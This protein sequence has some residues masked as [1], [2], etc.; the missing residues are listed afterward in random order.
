MIFLRPSAFI[1]ALLAVPVVLL[2]LRRIP[3]VRRSVATGFLWDQVF[4]DR[5]PGVAQLRRRRR[6][7]L[8]IQL[9]ILAFLVVALA[10]PLLHRPQRIV[11]VV[12]NSS[13]GASL[14][15]TKQAARATVDELGRHDQMAILTA[16]GA[17]HVRCGF[18]GRADELTAT[19]DDITTGSA[20]PKV[21][22]ALALARQILIGSENGQV[23]VIG[24]GRLS[25]TP[26]A[27]A[28]TSAFNVPRPA[29]WICL[30]AV[31]LMAAAIEWCMFQ[32][33]WTC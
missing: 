23:L 24:D 12:D 13:S 2:Y 14:D 5:R 21:E 27:D 30:A 3:L 20:P 19:V 17:P 7:S 9:S 28:Q 26:G 32:R 18:R 22:E 10:E 31:V 15:E 33:R 11:L 8:C 6:V 29:L 1:W 4:S 16:A 25:S